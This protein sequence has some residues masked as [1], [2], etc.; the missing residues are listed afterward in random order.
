M[1]SFIIGAVILALFYGLS[2][3]NQPARDHETEPEAPVQ[4]RR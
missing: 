3:H 2:W 4:Q 1:L